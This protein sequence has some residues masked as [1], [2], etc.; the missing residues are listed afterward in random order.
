MS[1]LWHWT[2]LNIEMWVLNYLCHFIGT[3]AQNLRGGRLLLLF[4]AVLSD[5]AEFLSCVESAFYFALWNKLVLCVV[6][7][8]Y[9]KEF[10]KP[11]GLQVWFAF[12]AIAIFWKIVFLIYMAAAL[13]FWTSIEITTEKIQKLLGSVSGVK[14]VLLGA[15]CIHYSQ[16]ISR[17]TYDSPLLKGRNHQ[18]PQSQT[19]GP[20][21]TTTLCMQAN[22]LWPEWLQ[23]WALLPSLQ[24]VSLRADVMCRWE[25]AVV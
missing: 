17:L 23:S 19:L 11:E 3:V 16:F 22:Y 6:M 9:R 4:N 20:A 14:C 8:Q 12:G 24:A 5:S 2:V 1:L 21:W 7:W 13:N 15:S 18:K 25:G 10:P